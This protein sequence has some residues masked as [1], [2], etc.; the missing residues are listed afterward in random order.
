MLILFVL[1]LE[2]KFTSIFVESS[3]KSV[4]NTK[5]LPLKNGD[6]IS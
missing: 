1:L 6:K 4:S 2:I 5:E 3:L